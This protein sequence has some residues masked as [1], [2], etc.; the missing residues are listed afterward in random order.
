MQRLTVKYHE[1]L[2]MRGLISEYMK[3]ET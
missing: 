2:Q 3:G 1:I